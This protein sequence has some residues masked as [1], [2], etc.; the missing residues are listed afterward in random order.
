MA[1]S[2]AQERWARRT[3][4]VVRRYAER[5]RGS[6][7]AIE[8]MAAWMPGGDTR[9]T[10]WFAPFP[11]V[12]ESAAGAVMR[13][14]DGRNYLD[15]LNNYTALV[16]GHRPPFVVEAIKAALDRDFLFGAP[17]EEQGVLAEH[18]V[19]RLPSAEQIR[20]CNSG[21]EATLLAARV[22]RAYTGRRQL[23]IAKYSYHGSGED[24]V[25][26]AAGVTGTTVFPADDPE[27]AVAV[28]RAAGP[29]AAVFI[30]PVLGSGGVIAVPVEVLQRLRR[31]AHET[32]ALLVF[33]EVQTLRLSYGG[34]QEATGVLPDLTAIGKIIGGGI[35]VGA[36]AGRRDVLAITDPRRPDRMEHSGTFNG[37][38]L[39][40]AGGLASLRALDRAAVERLNGLG[41]RL[42]TGLAAAAE[43]SEL[44][45]SVTG[46]GS[47]LNVHAARDVRS[48]AQAEAAAESP[49]RRLFH[50]GMLDRGVFVAPRGE[51][52][53]STA[54]TDGDVDAAVDAFRDLLEET[55]REL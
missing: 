31:F 23:A 15:F 5:H 51:L 38:R 36:V 53:C 29:L 11:L 45:F 25:W 21:T 44:P 10:T 32:G 49:L 33:D 17:M 24:L 28:L 27:A 2:A 1:D 26:E 39:T 6:L 12:M 55:A 35:P 9:S 37:Q 30:E 47:L 46:V 20:F 19:K 42:S 7:A 52:C 4:A 43:Q 16:H 18:I 8:R 34:M 22:A 13:D 50:L 54:M 48:A 3:D 40:M 14:V 41:M